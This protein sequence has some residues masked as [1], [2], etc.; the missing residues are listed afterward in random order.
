VAQH[1]RSIRAVPVLILAVLFSG[2]CASVP[3]EVV[4][5]SYAMGQDIEAVHQSYIELVQDRFDA[6]RAQRL[7]YYNEQWRPKFVE[8]WIRDGHLVDVA[9]GQL[10]WSK[11]D[12]KYVSPTAGQEK[13]QLLHSI[14]LWAQVALVKLDNKKKSLLDPIDADEKAMILEVDQAFSQINQ[15][16][17]T[18]TAHLNSLRKVQEVQDDALKALKMKDLRDKID[19]TLIRTSENAQKGLDD[20]KKADGFIE[21]AQDATQ[22]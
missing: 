20:V 14:Q 5:L 6:F 15:A 13:D 2:A 22:K 12:K 17:A 19:Q 8:G 11:S 10:V 9:S 16:N 7:Q 1:N 18:I 3:K 21:Q 4:E